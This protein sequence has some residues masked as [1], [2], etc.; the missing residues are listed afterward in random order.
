MFLA[1]AFF[2]FACGSTW[3]ILSKSFQLCLT[4]PIVGQGPISDEDVLFGAPSGTDE[5]GDTHGRG[6]HVTRDNGILSRGRRST[7][8]A[9]P[10]SA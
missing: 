2:E 7:N 3:T 9:K 10:L 5:T 1:A 8:K 6:S 4:R